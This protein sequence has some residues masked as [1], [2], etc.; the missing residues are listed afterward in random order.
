MIVVKM[1]VRHELAICDREHWMIDFERKKAI[2]EVCGISQ[3]VD[4]IV[5][6]EGSREITVVHEVK[7]TTIRDAVK[8]MDHIEANKVSRKKAHAIGTP[9][10][11]E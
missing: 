7:A 9:Q 1:I 10:F 6:Y 8:V 11:S 5:H 4:P 3:G 2:R